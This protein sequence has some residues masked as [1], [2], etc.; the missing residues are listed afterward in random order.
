MAMRYVKLSYIWSI[1]KV[2]E[3]ESYIEYAYG[4][5]VCEIKSYIE[6]TYSYGHTH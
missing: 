6:Y 5:E 3:I 1:R 4:H 2:Y